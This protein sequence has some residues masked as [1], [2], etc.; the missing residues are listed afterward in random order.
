MVERHFPY[1]ALLLSFALSLST[2]TVRIV[3]VPGTGTQY[4]PE[5]YVRTFVRWTL[6]SERK[7]IPNGVACNLPL[8]GPI[9]VRPTIDFLIKG[10]VPSYF[11]VGLEVGE[12]HGDTNEDEESQACTLLAE[13]W[14]TFSN[15]IEPGMRVLVYLGSGDGTDERIAFYGSNEVQNVLEVLAVSLSEATSDDIQSGFHIVSVPLS[16]DW[17]QSI[18]LSYSRI[19]CF[20]TSEPDARVLFTLDSTLLEMTATSVLQVHTGDLVGRSTLG[21]EDL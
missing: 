6:N 14:T 12:V 15:A 2:R 13:Q 20:A 16:T 1:V 11:M 7:L 9:R 5:P 10:G 8:V 18:P 3:G 19:T 17:I 4:L 21:R